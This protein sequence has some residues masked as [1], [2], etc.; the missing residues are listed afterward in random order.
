MYAEY[1]LK[2]DAEFELKE[3]PK[4]LNRLITCLGLRIYNFGVFFFKKEIYLYSVSRFA[5][6]AWV[7]SLN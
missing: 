1:L 6:S 5:T 2:S 3:C 7:C 4:T